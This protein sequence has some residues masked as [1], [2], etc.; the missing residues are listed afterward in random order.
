MKI[1]KLALG[2]VRKSLR[3]YTVYFLTIAF[4]VCIFYVFNSIESQQVMMDVTPSQQV[5]LRLLGSF[6]DVFSILISVVLCLLIIYA[7]GFLI[8]RRKKEFGVYLLL[9]MEKGLISRILVLET[10]LVGLVGLV[11]GLILGVGMSQIMTIVTAQLLNSA[12]SGYQFIFSASA[13]L[14][15]A[16]YFG[17]SFVLILIFNVITINRQ[18]LIN[19]LTDARKNERFKVLKPGR[20]LFLFGLATVAL[21]CAYIL[22]LQGHLFNNHLVFAVIVALVVVGTFLFFFALAG[23]FL[24]LFQQRRAFYLRNLNSFVARQLSSK[25]NTTYVSMSFVCLMLALAIATLASGVGVAAVLSE[26]QQR[27]APYDATISIE[28]HEDDELVPYA[29]LDVLQS[30]HFAGIDLESLAANWSVVPVFQ[31]PFILLA[32][33]EGIREEAEDFEKTTG[34]GDATNTTGLGD[35]TAPAGTDSQ[36]ANTSAVAD[37]APAADTSAD[38]DH[39]SVAA[40]AA[41]DA[42]TSAVDDADDPELLVEPQRLASGLIRISDFN[43]AMAQQGQKPLELGSGQFALHV[44]LPDRAL[45]QNLLD[46]LR[47]TPSLSFAAGILRSEPALLRTEP[48]ATI[49]TRGTQVDIIVP[50]VY[51]RKADGS[52]PP[53]LKTLVNLTYGSQTV[54]PTKASNT[55]ALLQDLFASLTVTSEDGTVVGF[56]VETKSDI[57]QVAYSAA[58]IVSYIALYLGMV[59]LITSAALLAITQLSETSDNISRY[60]LLRKLGVEARM[61]RGALFSQI[62]LYFLAPLLLALAH[63]TVGIMMLSQ[64]TSSLKNIDIFSSSTVAAVVIIVLYGGYF[65]ATY[66]G[67]RSILNREAINRRALN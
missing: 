51:V 66:G 57:V 26:E 35:A 40:S 25:L 33:G 42:D 65:L 34:L 67:S 24:R 9:G 54:A 31:S 56:A 16:L 20:S 7:N 49:A 1:S 30:L 6:M 13:V 64:L 44:D 14:K 53:V 2:N 38:T 19:L 8:R 46:Y 50:D 11:A 45:E 23:L 63:A 10:V 58:M 18:R 47:G 27:N 3:D 15:T 55:D 29:A 59:F 39:S 28:R 21:I 17:L 4:G 62:A 22:M 36:T 5:A 32:T 43:Q 52:L 61:L 60:R 48:I 37:H 12:I 41:D